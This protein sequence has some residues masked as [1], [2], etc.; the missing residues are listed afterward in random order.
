MCNSGVGLT[1]VVDDKIYHF[2]VCGVINGLAV[3]RDEETQ[4]LWDHISGECFEGSMAGKRL[5]FW[6]VFMT[7]VSAELTNHPD[8]M[9][10]KSNYRSLAQ[11]AFSKVLHNRKKIDGYNPI[12]PMFR[13]SMNGAVDP[14]RPESEQGFGIIVGD[15]GKYYPLA[16]LPKG[17]EIADEWLGRTL[18]IKR[19]ALDGVPFATWA[20]DGEAP[21]QL[22][23]RWY[24]FSFTYPDCVIFDGE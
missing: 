10:L 15:E 11:L 6:P 20:D 7:N 13:K 19:S 21:M 24:G 2:G 14:R 17:G 3:M 18:Q 8:T 1:P 22:L 16:S 23:T 5:D 9:L 4:S 12:P